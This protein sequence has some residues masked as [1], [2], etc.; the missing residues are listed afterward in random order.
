MIVLVGID[1]GY[2]NMGISVCHVEDSLDES[3][4]S[5]EHVAKVNLRRLGG[6]G[7]H[8]EVDTFVKEYILPK[9]TKKAVVMIERQP[10]T[11][12]TAIEYLILHILKE[13]TIVRV[14]PN[15][16]HKHFRIGCLCYEK[17]KAFIEK[18]VEKYFINN[19]YKTQYDNMTRKHD[20]A[21][22]ILFCL[23]YC[24]KNKVQSKN[25][26]DDFEL[27]RFVPLCERV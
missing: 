10:P 6:K 14:S 26:S 22:S 17:R 2:L 12:L 24:S 7:L 25:V 19:D 27:F 1:I 15:S 5:V 11:G 4:L 3:T 8:E 23:F 16:L 21:D 20:V 18:Y 9:L 13:Y